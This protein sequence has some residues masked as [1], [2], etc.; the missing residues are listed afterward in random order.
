[1]RGGRIETGGVLD[2]SCQPDG[3][4]YRLCLS[5]MEKMG[6]REKTFGDASEPLSD[7]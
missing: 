5:L 3:Q 2:Y 7:V 6:V 4:M 1:M